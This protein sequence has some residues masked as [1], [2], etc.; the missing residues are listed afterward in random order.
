MKTDARGIPVRG[1]FG[2]DRNLVIVDLCTALD[3]LGRAMFRAYWLSDEPWLP[4]GVRAQVFHT[5]VALWCQGRRAK[6]RTLKMIDG[7]EVP[8]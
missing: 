7:S 8:E 5:N 1:E 6:G 2:G 4:D 3:D